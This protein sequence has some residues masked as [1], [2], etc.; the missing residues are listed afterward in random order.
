MWFLQHFSVTDS[1]YCCVAQ[2]H[3]LL[4]PTHSS[5]KDTPSYDRIRIIHHVMI[6]YVMKVADAEG[7]VI[8]RETKLLELFGPMLESLLITSH[9][10]TLILCSPVL[11]LVG[12][13]QLSIAHEENQKGEWSERSRC[14]WQHS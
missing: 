7:A 11:V 6:H 4:S 1:I 9:H 8:E 3:I 10:L 13:I 5:T 14:F 2:Q 12:K